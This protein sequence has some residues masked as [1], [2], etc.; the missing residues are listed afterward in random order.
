MLP[1]YDDLPRSSSPRTYLFFVPTHSRAI[2]SM[3][4]TCLSLRSS[5]FELGRNIPKALSI[6]RQTKRL[7]HRLH[8]YSHLSAEDLENLCRNAG[9]LTPNLSHSIRDVTRKCQSCAGTGRPRRSKKVSLSRVLDTFN[10]HIQIDFFFVPELTNLPI[11]HIIDVSTSY[12]ECVLLPTREIPD[13]ISALKRRWFH[14]HGAP[15]NLSGDI[16]FTRSS[17]FTNFLKY[18][19]VNLAPRPARRHNKNG[20]VE[21]KHGIIRR[22]L[23]RFLKDASASGVNVTSSGISTSPAP[24]SPDITI[25]DLLARA[26]FLSNVL[27]GGKPLSA[28]E[29]VRGYTPSLAGLPQLPVSPVLFD[30]HIKQTARRAIQRLLKDKPD[31]LPESHLFP[32]NTPVY[33]FIRGPKFGKWHEGFVKSASQHI[34]EVSSRQDHRGT[35]HKVAY[36]DIRIKLD[37]SLLQELDSIGFKFPNSY[38]IINTDME[39]YLPDPSTRESLTPTPAPDVAPPIY[40]D[41]SKLYPD[42]SIGQ[43]QSDMNPQLD[44]LSLPDLSLD[45]D[46]DAAALYLSHIAINRNILDVD[47]SSIKHAVSLLTNSTTNDP[48]LDIG[49][50]NIPDK[51][52]TGASVQSDEQAILR[53]AYSTMKGKQMYEHELGSIPSWI[54]T[55]AIQNEK[56]NYL[57]EGCY[58]E[59]HAKDLP[60]QANIISSHHF[61]EVKTQGTDDI[62]RL[63]CRLV[64]HGNK[65]TE[66]ED[67]RTDAVT[68]QFPVIRYLLAYAAIHGLHLVS[69]DIKS[70]FLQAL[71]FTR[72]IY[73]KPPPGWTSSSRIYWRLLKPAY[74]LVD[75]PR[76]WQLTIEQWLTEMGFIMNVG[77]PQLFLLRDGNKEISVILVKVVDDLLIT[78]DASAVNYFLEE[79]Q[80]RF[81]VGRIVRDRTMI[82]NKLH[83]ELHPDKSI[84]FNMYEFLNSIK[85][86]TID[87]ERKKDINARCTPQEASDLRRLCGELNYIGHGVLPPACH[88]ASELLQR[89]ATLTIADIIFA[90]S[91]L[92]SLQKLNAKV[93]YRHTHTLPQFYQYL[94]FAD[95]SLGKTVYGQTGYLS[96]IYFHDNQDFYPIDWTSHKQSRITFSSMGAEILAGAYSA[97]RGS[98]LHASIQELYLHK[99]KGLFELVVDSFGLYGTVTTLREGKDYRLRPTVAR[100]RD[101]FESGEMDRI[102]WI[103]GSKNLAD[104]LTKY[105]SQA[106]LLLNEVMMDGR[107]NEDLFETSHVISHK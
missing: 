97:D 57:R 75:A 69:V 106:R 44:N 79:L 82:F 35:P 92:K 56:D 88:S 38:S 104:S 93:M 25:S 101:S 87:R 76:L 103:P 48:T 28:F 55:K 34:V 14:I 63:K 102:R 59:V 13:V 85:P 50:T 39:P 70:A 5:Y 7:A 37:N 31:A 86:I 23:L 36:E 21:A 94:T 32:P 12:S 49:E 17:D 95:A 2:S 6:A 20:S 100:L 107:L 54:I 19:F 71:G 73:V 53:T 29:Q 96:G 40:L 27:Y 43:Q 11:L 9:I 3:T 99:F 81:K 26:C 46:Q 51:L 1:T 24:S 52:P 22:L 41:P 67:I 15:S 90:N 65:D 61:F 98:L 42:D 77:M 47:P 33:F 74:G 68:A 30:A 60:P 45:S 66:K 89:S 8:A 80:K 72:E 83:I 78:G 91:N 62:L 64:P 18:F 84:S 10:S 58:E 4:T 105:N 16:E